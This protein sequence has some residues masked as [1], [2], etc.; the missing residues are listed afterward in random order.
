MLM[1][2]VTP[3]MVQGWK[4][5]YAIYRPMLRPNKRPVQ[6]VISYLTGKYPV[7]E[8]TDPT[9]L[10]VVSDNVTG[11]DFSA[12]KLPAG[13]SPDPRV[14]RIE[15]TG[16]GSDLYDNQDEVFRGIQIIVGFD[17]ETGNF[18][19]E[20]S[21]RLWDEL[22]I[23]MGL[24]EHDLTNYYLVAEYVECLRKFG[25]LN[26][27]ADEPGRMPKNGDIPFGPSGK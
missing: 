9:L 19:V 12:K 14:F 25:N 20:G 15:E 21:S 7:T 24:D 27:R 8:L 2:E 6:E 11:N 3:E 5:T 13:R 17:R 22:F 4:E 10:Q 18:M 23:F 26:Q 16:A 1:K